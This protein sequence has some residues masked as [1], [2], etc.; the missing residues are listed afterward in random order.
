MAINELLARG[1]APLDPAGAYRNALATRGAEQQMAYAKD[2]QTRKNALAARETAAFDRQAEDADQKAAHLETFRVGLQLSGLPPEQLPSAYAQAVAQAKAGPHGKYLAE[3]PDQFDPQRWQTF[4]QQSGIGT[5]SPEQKQGVLTKLNTGLDLPKAE[6]DYT[7]GNNR[8]KGGTNELLVTGAIKPEGA[9]FEASQGGKPVLVQRYSDGS[10]Q[11][12]KDFQPK[13]AKGGLS[14]QTNPDGTITFTEG[15]IPGG[16][17]KATR[18]NEEKELLDAQDSLA[19]LKQVKVAPEFLTYAGKGKSL[20]GGM[21][22]KLGQ[23]TENTKFNADRGAALQDVELFFNKYR[24]LITG[25][26]A[27]EKELQDLKKAVINADIGPQ[28]FTQRRDTLISSMEN[29]IAR[30]TRRLAGSGDAAGKVGAQKSVY[31]PK[32]DSFVDQ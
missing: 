6:A 19:S 15:D 23:T 5:L 22:D 31:D 32:T 17:S 24:K 1:V 30:K 28:E 20:V 27:A 11:P 26:A 12:V 14:L 25:A 13:P 29:D 9:P 18:T 4:V 10:L 21:Q 2:D 7:L 8:Y 3:L 16:L